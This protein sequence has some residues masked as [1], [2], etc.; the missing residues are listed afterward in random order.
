M[1]SDHRRGF[2][3]SCSIRTEVFSY[4]IRQCLVTISKSDANGGNCAGFQDCG[5]QFSF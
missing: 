1:L 2:G 3:I 5:E 4:V